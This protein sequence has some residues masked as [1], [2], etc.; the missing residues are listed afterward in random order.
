MTTHPPSLTRRTHHTPK[1]AIKIKL[2]NYLQPT[3]F[4][5]SNHNHIHIHIHLLIKKK[6][7]KTH[8][9]KI[10]TYISIINNSLTLF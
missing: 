7:E 2:P 4:C 8:Q 1:Q 3:H 5:G 10:Y 9:R 6:K